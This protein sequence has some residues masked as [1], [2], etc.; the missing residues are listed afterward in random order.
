MFLNFSS[1]FLYN[2]IKLSFI[3]NFS[4]KKKKLYSGAK[5]TLFQEFMSKL[6]SDQ[7]RSDHK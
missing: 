3:A 5:I 2:N 7:I 4:I 6:G 1:T